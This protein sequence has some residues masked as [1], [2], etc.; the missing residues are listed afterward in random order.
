MPG[1][2]IVYRRSTGEVHVTEYASLREATEERLRLD[3]SRKDTD[4]EIVSISARDREALEF[5]HSRYF[6]RAASPA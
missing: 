2:L 1:F 6:M 3:R 5:S 4:I